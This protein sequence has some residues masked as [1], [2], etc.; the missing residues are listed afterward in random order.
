MARK[1]R[2]LTPRL[3]RKIV[4]EEKRKMQETLESGVEDIEKVSA[5]EV[6]ADE[7]AGSLEKDIDF[8]K[9]LKISE[10][11]LSKKLRR[12]R[13]VKKKLRRRVLRRL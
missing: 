7:L 1:L 8:M 5:E 4:L 2:H 13:E 9:A 10:S 12:V 6:D 11:K 3:L